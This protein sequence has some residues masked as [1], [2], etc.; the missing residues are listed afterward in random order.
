MVLVL[1]SD[2]EMHRGYAADYD[3][4]AAPSTEQPGKSAGVID[5]EPPPGGATIHT[6][7]SE[8][9]CPEEL[10][11]A[12]PETTP[13]RRA[14]VLDA[15]PTFVGAGPLVPPDGR[16]SSTLAAD[17][18]AVATTTSPHP[19]TQGSES[20]DLVHVISQDGRTF[21]MAFDVGQ[22][23]WERIRDDAF[24]Y[25]ADHPRPSLD[26]Y[27]YGDAQRQAFVS[28]VACPPGGKA[29][30]EAGVSAST[31]KKLRRGRAVEE[32]D[33]KKLL[34]GYWQA[35]GDNR[36]HLLED[37]GRLS[38]ADLWRVVGG[39]PARQH[40]LLLLEAPGDREIRSTQHESL[41]L[42][43]PTT[44]SGDVVDYAR[45]TTAEMEDIVAEK[46][47]GERDRDT[48]RYGLRFS[49]K[50]SNSHT[51]FSPTLWGCGKKKV[52][53]YTRCAVWEVGR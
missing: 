26:A 17:G 47:L 45:T 11:A 15:A 21:T 39:G 16:S 43:A 7:P 31:L 9:P 22:T 51:N 12:D 2:E 19:A 53:R 24:A 6:P 30:G 37:G 33:P 49:P 34:R 40:F 8:Q 3:P 35:V 13:T 27:V 48:H 52:Y 29:K 36:R 20:T 4:A 32:L 25:F 38:D 44:E 18:S 10:L 46:T 28:G 5:A 23:V 41:V 1:S 42:N 14:L 50:W